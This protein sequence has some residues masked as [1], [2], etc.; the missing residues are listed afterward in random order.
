MTQPDTNPAK[1]PPAAAVDDAD[2]ALIR[3]MLKLTPAE[4]LQ[5]LES[6]ARLVQELRDANPALRVPKDT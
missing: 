3:E 5:H 1:P 4:R 6:H 2:L